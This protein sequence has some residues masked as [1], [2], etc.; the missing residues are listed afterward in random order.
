M[1]VLPLLHSSWELSH[2]GVVPGALRCRDCSVCECEHEEIPKPW[3]EAE[4]V[5]SCD[6]EPDC[7]GRKG[8]AA[9]IGG[10]GSLPA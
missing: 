2:G 7:A 10:K 1:P 5:D 4:A 6:S 9:W 3:R 8:L